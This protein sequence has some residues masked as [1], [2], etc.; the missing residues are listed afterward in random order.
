MLLEA[1]RDVHRGQS[2]LHPTIAHKLIQELQAPSDLPPTETPLT[3]R[4][5]EVLRGQIAAEAARL[6]DLGK[7]RYSELTRLNRSQEDRATLLASLREKIEIEGQEVEPRISTGEY[8]ATAENMDTDKFR[9]LLRPE[10][11]GE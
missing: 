8:V 7:T 6:E 1:I 4:E 3:K 5:L 10:L 2:S 11:F 9:Q